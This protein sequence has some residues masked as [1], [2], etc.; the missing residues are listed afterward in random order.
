MNE[1]EQLQEDNSGVSLGTVY[2]NHTRGLFERVI[3]GEGH[4]VKVC[5]ADC[6]QQ[7]G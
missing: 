6:S 3:C 4:L 5:P 1:D 7:A 2:S